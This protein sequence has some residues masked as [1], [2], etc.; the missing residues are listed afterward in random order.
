MRPIVATN[1]LLALTTPKAKSQEKIAAAM[2]IQ[3]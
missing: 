3:V 2:M 1:W